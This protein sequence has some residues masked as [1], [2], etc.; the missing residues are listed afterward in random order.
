[1]RGYAWPFAA[2]GIFTWMQTASD[3][4]ALQGRGTSEVGFYAAL[5]Q[6][7][8]YPMTLLSGFLVR[9]EEHTSELQSRRDLVCR[10]LLEKKNLFHFSYHFFAASL[11]LHSF[12]TR[13]SSDLDARLCLA[14]CRLGNLHLDANGLRPLG[15]AGARHQRSWLLCRP[16]P[17]RLLS[18]DIAVRIPGEIGRAHV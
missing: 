5:Y 3:R 15:L 4:W 12:P 10:L 16:L 7:G 11:F 13:R 9:S 1:M 2:W 6:L 8:Y 17:T 18:D 14:I